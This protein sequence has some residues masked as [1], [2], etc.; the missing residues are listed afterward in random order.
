MRAGHLSRRNTFTMVSNVRGI[1]VADIGSGEA[2][3]II[4]YVGEGYFT[5]NAAPLLRW[6]RS[7]GKQV[8][9]SKDLI[10]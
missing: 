5:E 10:H 6:E 4:T 7:L 8:Y 1:T 9:L 3:G 2:E